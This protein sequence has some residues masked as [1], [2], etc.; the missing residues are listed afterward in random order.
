MTVMIATLAMYTGTIARIGHTGPLT[1]P[2]ILSA[3][4][5]TPITN[6]MSRRRDDCQTMISALL[7]RP[8]RA[9]YGERPISA[10]SEAS[11]GSLFDRRVAG[12]SGCF[13]GDG[14]GGEGTKWS[15]EGV[16]R[17][18]CKFG[19]RESGRGNRRDVAVIPSPDYRFP[20]PGTFDKV[21]AA[22]L[23]V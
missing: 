14:L 2:E 21:T 17:V 3:A 7:N 22:A 6:A 20:N 11:A 8:T 12:E 4:A 5:T 1:I 10:P 9:A 19:T 16:W 18:T 15:L 13:A 23:R